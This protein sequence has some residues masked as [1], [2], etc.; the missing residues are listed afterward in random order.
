MILGDGSGPP[1][2]GR[3]TFDGVLDTPGRKV[4]V[5]S[6]FDEVVL[7]L[8]VAA[9]RTRVRIWTNDHAEPSEIYI[10]ATAHGV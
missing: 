1:A 2:H 6:V 3:P 5:C 8:A 7:E 10:L 4:A 9:K